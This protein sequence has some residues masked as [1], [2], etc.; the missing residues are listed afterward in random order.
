MEDRNKNSK[1][2][3]VRSTQTMP[4]YQNQFYVQRLDAIVSHEFLLVRFY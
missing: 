3:H 1:N 4:L 2:A